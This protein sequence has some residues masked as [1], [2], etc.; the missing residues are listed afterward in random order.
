MGILTLTNDF[1]GDLGELVYEHYSKQKN[2][3]YI[4]TEDI[5]H[6]YGLD[7]LLTFRFDRERLRVKIPLA[8]E[9]EIVKYAKP[10]G[11]INHDKHKPTFVFDY[12]SINKGYAHLEEPLSSHFQWAEIKTD[13]GN[14][15]PNQE[16]R[17]SESKIGV[18]I[19]RVLLVDS[20]GNPLDISKIQIQR[21]EI[22]KLK[23]SDQPPF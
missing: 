18:H 14:L 12:L 15:S 11:Y 21:Q 13:T 7:S 1:K 23:K 19:F 20:I 6:E 8:V 17:A 4:K 22:K 3:A 5:Y 16:K 10:S 9:E 2:F